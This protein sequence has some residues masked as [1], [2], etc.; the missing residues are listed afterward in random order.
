VSSDALAFGNQFGV[1]ATTAV[2][3]PMS[4]KDFLDGFC[5]RLDWLFFSGFQITIEAA[6]A[7]FQDLT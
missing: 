5:Q 4:P 3:P 7:N 2:A 6:F 1:N